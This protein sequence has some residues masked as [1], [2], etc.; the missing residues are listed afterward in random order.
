VLGFALA[1]SELAAAVALCG[2]RRRARQSER[3]PADIR[4]A[5]AALSASPVVPV[6]EACR[7]LTIA[8]Q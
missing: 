8:E 1:S 3:Q 4:A 2:V 7:G 6:R 5:L